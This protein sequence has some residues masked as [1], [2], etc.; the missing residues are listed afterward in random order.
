VRQLWLVATAALAIWFIVVWPVQALKDWQFERYDY[1]RA[2]EKEF[3]SGEGL[4]YQTARWK[5]F[6]SPAIAKTAGTSILAE[7]TTTQ[8]PIHLRLTKPKIPHRTE[9]STLRH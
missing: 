8:F 7:N 3:E 9:M 4:T 5:Q 1:E 6:K 2:I